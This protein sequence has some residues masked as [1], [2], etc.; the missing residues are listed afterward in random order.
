MISFQKNVARALACLFAL[1]LMLP[2]VACAAPPLLSSPDEPARALEDYVTRT[3]REETVLLGVKDRT[4]EVYHIPDGVSTVD[5]AAFWGCNRAKEIFIPKS[6]TKIGDGFLRYC[7]RVES[8]TVEEGNPVYVAVDHTLLHKSTRRVIAGCRTS[9]IPNDGSV[10]VIGAY[11]F[12]GQTAL[13]EISLPD[14]LT[15]I[16]EGAFIGCTGL[17]SLSFP[18]SLSSIGPSAFYG[19]IRIPTVALEGDVV[20]IGENAFRGCLSLYSVT[21]GASLESIGKNA[22]LGCEK[23]IE[24]S[25]RSTLS[26]KMG[27]DAHGCVALY[28]KNVSLVK[29]STAIT[30]DGDFLFFETKDS[31]FLIAYE[32]DRDTVTLP[33]T[34]R[35]APYSLYNYA[36]YASPVKD[37]T[38]PETVTSLGT[39]CFSDCTLLEAVQLPK[40]LSKIPKNCFHGC[41]ALDS[42]SLPDALTV[43]EKDAFL[44]ASG[45][46]EEED[47]ILYVDNWAVGCKPLLEELEIREETVGIADHAFTS[48]GAS[49][50]SMTL[51]EGVKYIGALAFFACTDLSDTSF[52]DSLLSIGESAFE[53]CRAIEELTLGDDLQELGASAFSDCARLVTFTVRSEAVTAGAGAFARCKIQSARLPALLVPSVASKELRSVV[54]TSGDMIPQMAFYDCKELGEVFIASTV[55]EIGASA[56]G[57]GSHLATVRY[58]GS[59]S[60]W[61]QIKI[62]IHNDALSNTDLLFDQ[63]IP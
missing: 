20:S 8:I 17:A 6:V 51:P 33:T 31:S 16:E 22:F 27:S 10:T 42:L 28:A 36:F 56:F 34:H 24:L 47:G 12:A 26:F 62:G 25:N 9:R 54:I 1:L 30:R 15:V 41:T 2:C 55:T 23:L 38:I 5:Q 60:D 52:P 44:G 7:D 39:G 21:L 50:K 4:K 45:L 32:G 57:N 59:Q 53:G 46:M 35:D 37:V 63:P 3:E 43:I 13:E 48:L 29:D 49:L 14:S 19:C 40:T 18:N 11:A 58:E 61:E